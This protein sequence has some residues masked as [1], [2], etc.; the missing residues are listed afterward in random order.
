MAFVC[1][2]CLNCGTKNTTESKAVGLLQPYQ[3]VIAM[4]CMCVCVRAS[5]R[6]REREREG[7]RER[8]RWDAVRQVI[9]LKPPEK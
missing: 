1:P 4:V 6:E 2:V 7:E 8:E 9:F 5:K 3:P